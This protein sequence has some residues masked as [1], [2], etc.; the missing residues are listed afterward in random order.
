MSA[1][2]VENEIK[3]RIPDAATARRLL[4]EHGFHIDKE[5]IFEAN[6]VYDTPACHLRSRGVL[7]RLRQAGDRNVVTFKGVAQPGRHKSR[8]ETEV[9]VSDFAG[10]D[11]ILRGL[12]Y[13]PRFRYEKYRTEF[14]RD[15]EQG[16][17]T[18]D[19]TPIGCFMELEG[20]A[21][22]VDRTAKTLGFYESEYLTSSYSELYLDFCRS[23]RV[24]PTHMTF[25]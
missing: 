3:L 2:G 19:E 9:T 10:F 11:A 5:R 13:E 14:V 18:V 7:L 20:D 1:N 22:W 23:R 4:E 21:E 15:G 6:Q 12:G 25:S 24:E 8:P 16:T 17:V